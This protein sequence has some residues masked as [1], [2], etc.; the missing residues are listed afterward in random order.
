MKLGLL[1]D[2]QLGWMLAEAAQ[3][4]GIEV[5]LWSAAGTG[6]AVRLC[7]DHVVAPLDYAPAEAAG[8]PSAFDAFCSGL[9]VVTYE[10]EH[11]SLGLVEAL[12]KRVPVHPAP[13]VLALAQDRWLEKAALAA[14]GLEVAPHAPCADR[15]TLEE[16]LRSV[17]YRALLKTRRDG[18][19]GKGQWRLDSPE[20]FERL[21]GAEDAG[22]FRWPASGCVLE[23]RLRFDRE[24]SLVLTRDASGAFAAH[25]WTEN[26][27]EHGILY[28]SRAPV[29]LPKAAAE[30]TEARLK[31]W[32]DSHRYV[33][34]L[35]L[36]C[37]EVDGRLVANEIAPRV[38]NSGHW[39][40]DGAR[41]SQFENHIRAVCGLGLGSAEARGLAA[42]VNVVG[43]PANPELLARIPGA[44][45]YDYAKAPRARRKLAHINLCA[46]ADAALTS[47]LAALEALVPPPEPAQ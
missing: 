37:F 1:G 27:H 44:R 5:R 35:A 8:G 12:A 3:R 6:T 23:R 47:A 39:T 29:A 34:T 40:L 10:L 18:Y 13:A 42:M 43:V 36:E 41:T 33:G 9:D 32:L 2:G 7:P 19:D 22:H 26:R 11:L 24:L 20:D 25:P 31:D 21:L 15:K 17:G 4:L 46:D 14:A 38:H 45:L 16:A 30:E 28:T